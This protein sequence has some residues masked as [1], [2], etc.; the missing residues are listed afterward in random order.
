MTAAKCG[1]RGLGEIDLHPDLNRRLHVIAMTNGA[2]VGPNK[3][4]QG[5]AGP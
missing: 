4:Q 1:S 5:R 2:Q 3:L